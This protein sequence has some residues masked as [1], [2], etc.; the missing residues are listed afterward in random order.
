MEI[1]CGLQ[2]S[3]E[4]VVFDKFGAHLALP[5]GTSLLHSGNKL[6]AYKRVERE[7]SGFG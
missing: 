3:R 5:N 1:N 7:E 2:E 6:P 4:R